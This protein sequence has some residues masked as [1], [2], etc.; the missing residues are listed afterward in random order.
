MRRAT[1]FQPTH[2]DNLQAQYFTHWPESPRWSGL[3]KRRTTHPRRWPA[4]ECSGLPQGAEREKGGGGGRRRKGGEAFPPSP[5][6]G[7]LHRRH[8]RGAGLGRPRVARAG[9]PTVAFR[10]IQTFV[11]LVLPGEL[12]KHA[13][14]EPPRAPRLLPLTRLHVRRPLRL[15][16]SGVWCLQLQ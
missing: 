1:S 15:P 9:S 11:R 14:S 7:L 4:A 16:P 13:V 8:L 10:G 3:W 12:A 5:N 6:H 2:I